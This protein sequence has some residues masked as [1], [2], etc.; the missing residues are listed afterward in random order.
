MNTRQGA[1]WGARTKNK[2][3]KV[4]Q[5][6]EQAAASHGGA[7]EDFWAWQRFKLALGQLGRHTLPASQNLL[8]TWSVE[9]TSETPVSVPIS[10]FSGPVMLSK[11]F[12]GILC[13]HILKLGK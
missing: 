7:R 10:S 9:R 1:V 6:W 3:R 2:H 8:T 5:I 12:C 4:L 11:D 13:F